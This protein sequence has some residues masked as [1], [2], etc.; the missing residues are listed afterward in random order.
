[1]DAGAE[2]MWGIAWSPRLSGRGKVDPGDGRGE[3][4]AEG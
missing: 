1:M 3:G 2:E 4:A